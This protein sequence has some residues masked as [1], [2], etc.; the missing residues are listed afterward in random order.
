MRT[1]TF[2]NKTQQIQHTI[3][4]EAPRS[5]WNSLFS[6][7]LLVLVAS[8]LFCFSCCFG[9]ELSTFFLCCS[10]YELDINCFF[11]SLPVVNLS[12]VPHIFSVIL[13][14][15][16]FGLR[17]VQKVK[18]RLLLR[19]FCMQQSLFSLFNQSIHLPFSHHAVS[20]FVWWAAVV[21]RFRV[22]NEEQASLLCAE[23]LMLHIPFFFFLFSNIFFSFLLSF[24][25]CFPFSFFFFF[26]FINNK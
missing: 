21:G 24:L 6:L 9:Y 16:S 1:N 17:D 12:P 13:M 25:I 20:F 22:T 4:L 7:K 2:E 10:E 5:L 8:P 14:R 18:W 23:N 26:F 3:P 11:L 15:S 19:L